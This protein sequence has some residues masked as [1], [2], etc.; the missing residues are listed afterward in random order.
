MGKKVLQAGAR[1]QPSGAVFHEVRRRPVSREF[2]ESL[3]DDGVSEDTIKSLE[4]NRAR[5]AEGDS[6]A[7]E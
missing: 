7:D 4:R 1:R 2:I 5:D 6:D 3:A